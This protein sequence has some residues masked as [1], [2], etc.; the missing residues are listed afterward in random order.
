MKRNLTGAESGF[1]LIET[2]FVLFLF[3][4]I[5]T[6]AM[7]AFAMISQNKVEKQFA[8]EVRSLLES[9]RSLAVSQERSW[10]VF[11]HLNSLQLQQVDNGSK[12]KT[13]TIPKRCEMN[14]NFR[15][16]QVVFRQMGHAVG[17]TLQLRCESGYEVVWKVQ[18]GSGRVIMEERQ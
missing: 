5:C 1:T 12:H 11:F 3:T 18:V 6:L 17:G 9:A 2:L 7:P 15:R 10:I 16:G 14:H 4:L 8:M 13:I